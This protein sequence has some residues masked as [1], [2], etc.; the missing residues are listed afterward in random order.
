M[1]AVAAGQPALNP[2]GGEVHFF[3]R[4]A[5]SAPETDGMAAVPEQ[6]IG[7]WGCNDGGLVGMAAVPEQATCPP[8]RLEE[9]EE[10]IHHPS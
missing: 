5:L 7:L 1:A 6:A 4:R 2:D 9:A 8:E 3:D 10:R